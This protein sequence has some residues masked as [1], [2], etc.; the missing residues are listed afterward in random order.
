MSLPEF[1]SAFELK[2][3]LF[4]KS[5]DVFD[6]TISKYLPTG[7]DYATSIATDFLRQQFKESSIPGKEKVSLFSRLVPKY[8]KFSGPDYSA[9]QYGNVP[10]DVMIST[11]AEDKLDHAT[12]RHDLLYTLAQSKDDLKRADQQLLKDFENIKDTELTPQASRY[13]FLA[14]K[15]F[16]A[17]LA[18]GVGYFNPQE[19]TPLDK[20]DRIKIERFLSKDN[21]YG[22]KPLD[23]SKRRKEIEFLEQTTNIFQQDDDDI[24]SINMEETTQLEVPQ[25]PIQE[26]SQEPIQE[27][28]QDPIETTTQTLTTAPMMQAETTQVPSNIFSFENI[29]TLIFL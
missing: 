10:T 14:E 22:Y 21:E 12:K 16:R 13:K 24:F 28:S 11:K 3:T 26:P 1:L 25:E 17:K 29:A 8:G 27:S 4:K 2:D 19:Q 20:T 7:L 18:T 23:F 15:T 6:N 9:G 5:L